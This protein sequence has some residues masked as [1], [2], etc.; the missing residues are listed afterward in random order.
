[1]WIPTSARVRVTYKKGN[2]MLSKNNI[3]KREC[4]E[5]AFSFSVSMAMPKGLWIRCKI[6]SS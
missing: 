5:Y 2:R 3:W 6:D 1:M 4:V